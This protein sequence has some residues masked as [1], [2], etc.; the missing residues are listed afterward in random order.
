MPPK[1][2]LEGKHPDDI[3][4]EVKTPAVTR[5]KDALDKWSGI[6]LPGAG[7]RTLGELAASGASAVGIDL[8][9]G[10][11]TPNELAKDKATSDGYDQS[12]EE[13]RAQIAETYLH[14]EKLKE[15]LKEWSAKLRK[16][17]T[18][19]AEKKD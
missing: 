13:A 15:E 2:V 16:L 9:A 5:A 3:T 11:P 14:V 19:L 1:P 7:G 6:T 10:A 4:R 12:Q 8:P 18:S 17:K